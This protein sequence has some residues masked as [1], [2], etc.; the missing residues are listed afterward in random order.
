MSEALRAV[1]SWSAVTFVAVHIGLAL[2]AAGIPCLTAVIGLRSNKLLKIFIDKFGQ[3]ATTFALLGGVWAFLVLCLGTAGLAWWSPAEVRSFLGFSG[4]IVRIAAP[5]LLGGL[6][7][8]AYRGLWQKLKAK[9]AAHALLGVATSLF[10]WLAIGVTLAALRPLTTGLPA[11][12]ESFWP[13]GQ[14][15]FWRVWLESLV[16]SLHVAG[17]FTGA[18]L[19][20]RRG[21]D[22]FGR[23]YYNFTMR[24]S[25][26]AGFGFGVAALCVVVW[27]CLGLLPGFG[28]LTSRL[29]AA[30]ALY[31]TGMLLAL[32]GAGFVASRQNALPHKIVLL[33]AFVGT[34]MELTGLLVGVANM[35]W[36]AF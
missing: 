16:L 19:V 34:V 21:K 35:S 2:A 17:T 8:L 23:D 32:C 25:A 13:T 7:F 9:K 29:T 11:A 18:W 33:V 30:V 3:Q 12:G 24:L 22:D 10:F 6:L 31:G 15:V 4:A 36:L 5:L 1:L 28:E 14:T 20:W 27:I 26:G